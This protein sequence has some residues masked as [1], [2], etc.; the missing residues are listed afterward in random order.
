MRTAVSE[1]KY[2]KQISIV[3]HPKQTEINVMVAGAVHIILRANVN[4]NS[5]TVEH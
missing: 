2:V 1:N 4:N 5:C 3:Y